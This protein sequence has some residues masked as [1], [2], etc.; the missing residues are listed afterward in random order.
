MA[1]VQM[2]DEPERFMSRHRRAVV[3]VLRSVE[4]D[5]IHEGED[6]TQS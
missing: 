6:S 4:E 3:V 5:S 2:F 1:E